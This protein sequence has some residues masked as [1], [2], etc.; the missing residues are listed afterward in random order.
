LK[1]GQAE[2]CWS[3][4]EEGLSEARRY[5][6]PVGVAE[7]LWLDGENAWVMLDNGRQ[8]RGDGERRPILWQF[9]APAD[10]WS[11]AP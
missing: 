6:T 1:T 4:A 8:S 10:G 5:D 7:G 11:A 9:A 2:R 3:F